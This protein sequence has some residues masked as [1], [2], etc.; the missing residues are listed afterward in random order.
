M[1]TFFL[2]IVFAAIFSLA[3]FHQVL[4]RFHSKES[5]KHFQELGTLFFFRPFLRN[6]F[7]HHELDS[8][9]FSLITS[10]NIYRFIFA[11]LAVFFSDSLSISPFLT[12]G[13][14]LLLLITIGEMIPRVLATRYPIHTL[15]I[16]APLVSLFMLGAA[17]VTIP[18]LKLFQL[19]THTLFTPHSTAPESA[20]K[21]E[22]IEVIQDADLDVV[23]DPVDKELIE[24]VISFSSRIAREVMVPRVDIFAL[25]AKT[26]IIQAAEALIKEGFS[27]VPI[28][29]GTIDNVIGILMY[30]DIL[31]KYMEVVQDPSKQSLLH[32]PIESIVKPAL[33]TPETKKISHLLQEFRKKQVHMA[34]VVD[35]YGGT[36]GIVTIEDILEEIVGEISDEYD[37]DD[38]L[39]TPLANGSWIVDAKMSINDL[40]EEL[41]ISI[42]Q[43]GEFDTVGGYIY[44]RTGTIPSRGFIIDHD[45]F[46]LQI[47]KSTERGVEKVK[48]TPRR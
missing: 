36:E 39:F 20:V 37:R 23:L 19:F 32:S 30:K 27:R 1:I 24:S 43:E 34:I 42:P 13:L 46:T 35:E 14:I 6:F 12:L 21:Q 33:Y 17:P 5:K 18:L 40:E 16:T 48:I 8:L 3:A 25:S 26:P 45:D 31:Q 41:N 11:L 29:E 7:P 38:L 10:Q 4:R 2:F 28:Y 47:L 44:H 22:L 9:L 15:S